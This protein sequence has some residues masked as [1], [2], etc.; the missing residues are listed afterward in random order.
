MEKSVWKKNGY[1]NRWSKL[2]PW[3]K[4]IYSIDKWGT[5]AVGVEWY[6]SAPGTQFA[7]LSRQKITGRAR[8]LQSGSFSLLNAFDSNPKITAYRVCVNLIPR[9]PRMQDT[10]S[11]SDL[12]N[13]ES[14]LGEASSDLSGSLCVLAAMRHSSYAVFCSHTQS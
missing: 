6:G 11:R 1:S 5:G 8:N 10:T 9:P 4:K 7:L 14:E 12:D 2:L 13:W 3:S